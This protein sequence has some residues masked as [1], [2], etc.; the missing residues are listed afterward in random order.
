MASYEDII[1]E[2]Q[3][4]F[5]QGTVVNK[6]KSAYI[7]VQAYLARLEEVAGP[8]WHWRI[9]GEPIINKEMQTVMIKGEITIFTTVRQ[10]IGVAGL[11][12]FDSSSIKNSIMTAE[13]ES[14]RDACDKFQMGW[15]DLA[16]Y[17]DWSNNPGV[18]F[19]NEQQTTKIENVDLNVHSLMPPLNNR[20]CIRCNRALTTE[21]ELFLSVNRVK[22]PYCKD[23]VPKQFIK[24]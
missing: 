19:K 16:P 11:K 10:G 24:Q 2:L 7:P 21:E 6:N 5:P 20:V 15:K 8:H 22:H 18:A 4:P 12:K 9:I 17:R 23:H 3:R 1:K 13:S 14:L